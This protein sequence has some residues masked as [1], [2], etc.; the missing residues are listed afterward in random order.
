MIIKE[1]AGCGFERGIEKAQ[2]GIRT[3]WVGMVNH[4]V[5]AKRG[6]KSETG[7]WGQANSEIAGPSIG[8]CFKA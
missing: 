5:W 3:E 8:S 1:A 2:E 7:I 6:R 4:G